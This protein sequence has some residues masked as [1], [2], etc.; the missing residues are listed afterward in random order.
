MVRQLQSAQRHVEGGVLAVPQPAAPAEWDAGLRDGA[1]LSTS[2][3]RLVAAQASVA[4]HGAA[5]GLRQRS[6]SRCDCHRAGQSAVTYSSPT[7]VLTTHVP[8]YLPPHAL[9]VYRCVGRPTVGAGE[10]AQEAAEGPAADR[11][12]QGEGAAGR[13]PREDAAGQDRAGGRAARRARRAQQR[14]GRRGRRGGRRGHRHVGRHCRHTG[15]LR[16]G[17]SAARRRGGGSGLRAPATRPESG[18]VDPVRCE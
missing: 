2:E 1:A 15:A 17:G 14:G 9:T 13:H 11:R 5:V 8:T 4:A 3:G 16:R 12:P 10:E 7:H 18:R 6:C